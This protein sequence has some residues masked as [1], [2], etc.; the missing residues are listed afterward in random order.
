MRYN[1]TQIVTLAM[2]PFQEAL[3]SIGVS[4]F[5]QFDNVAM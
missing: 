2:R 1:H 3:G 5:P 4:A